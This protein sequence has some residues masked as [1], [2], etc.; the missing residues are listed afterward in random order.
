MEEGDG[1]RRKRRKNEEEEDSQG[2]H[3]RFFL[4]GAGTA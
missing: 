2:R 4:W 3:F 1:G